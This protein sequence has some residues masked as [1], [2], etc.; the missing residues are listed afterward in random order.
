MAVEFG[1]AFLW[2][3]TLASLRVELM[4][5]SLAPS[6]L[7]LILLGDSLECSVLVLRYLLSLELV[8]WPS[9]KL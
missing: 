3:T 5:Y 6:A 1:D 7:T 9:L 8:G 4:C 2:V